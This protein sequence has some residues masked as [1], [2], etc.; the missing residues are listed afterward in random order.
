MRIEVNNKIYHTRYFP[1]FRVRRA[2]T[3]DIFALRYPS[4][5][6]EEIMVFDSK[7]YIVELKAYLKFLIEEYMHEEDIALTTFG[8]RLKRDVNDLFFEEK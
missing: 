1:F 7:N 4:G 8:Q 6:V 2:K 5:F 3:F